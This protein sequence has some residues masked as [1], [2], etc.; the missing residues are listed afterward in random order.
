MIRDQIILQTEIDE[1]M[2]QE[3]VKEMEAELEKCLPF[4]SM[5]EDSIA[6]LTL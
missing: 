6:R 3:S 1:Y 4:V 5:A 2:R